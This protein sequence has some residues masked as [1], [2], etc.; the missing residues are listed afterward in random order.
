[1]DDVK[2]KK[3]EF[4]Y[5]FL[6]IEWNQAP[7]TMDLDGREAIQIGVV[8]TDAKMQKAKTFSKAI[9]LSDPNVFNEQ[10]QEITHTPLS[11]IMKGNPENVIL[12]NFAKAF[13]QYHYIV[14]WNKETYKLFKRDMIKCNIRTKRHKTLV[15]QELLGTLVE[16]GDKPISFEN[17]LECAG[18][19]Y[20][21]N[22]LHYSKHDAEYL[23]KLFGQCYQQY[24]AFTEGEYCIA[25]IA[26]RKLHAYSCHCVKIIP[27]EN[28]AKAP[29]N[30][31]FQGF[32]AC[33]CCSEEQDLKK[34]KWSSEC[35]HKSKE[36]RYKE[37]LKQLPLTEEN[38][39]KI[40]EW[41]RV[42]C[43][44]SNYT[45][46]VK[47]AFSRW[48]IHLEDNKVN[49]LY[50]ENY[51]TSKSQYLKKQKKKSTEGYHKQKLPSEQFFDVIQYIKYHDA[52][53]VRKI[54]RKSRLEEL[55]ERVDRELKAK[56]AEEN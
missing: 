21:P 34:F 55:L 13:P 8:A 38:I 42:S 43:S 25:N 50:H 39:E 48:V 20:L 45:V 36:N 26:T 1:M 53:I 6:D 14:V 24:S 17:A 10:T 27:Q 23:Y 11:N 2:G 29:K 54:S 30:W 37:I 9:R 22:F 47:T 7:G 4:E 15:L 44:I 31:I 16:N 35:R 56:N 33:R 52:G 32:V 3:E 28:K 46:F 51:K 41:F 49:E 12:E 19:E 18:I 5:L 40:C